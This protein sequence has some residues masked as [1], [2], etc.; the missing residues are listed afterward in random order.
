MI[1]PR[2]RAGDNWPISRAFLG[3]CLMALAVV[4]Q[5]PKDTQAWGTALGIV[6][7]AVSGGARK[8]PNGH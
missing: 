4:I 6:A 1:I 3:A 5:A 8:D 2:R 7:A